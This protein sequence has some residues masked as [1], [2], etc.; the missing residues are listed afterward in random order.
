M[1]PDYQD[2][3]WMLVDIDLSKVS[4]KAIRLNTSLPE[5]LAQKIDAAASAQHLSRPAF[6]AKAALKELAKV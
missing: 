1:H 3:F 6:L 2:G 5:K 4:T